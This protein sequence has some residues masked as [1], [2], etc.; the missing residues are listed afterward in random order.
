MTFNVTFNYVRFFIRIIIRIFI[1][2][3]N[4]IRLFI[5]IIIINFSSTSSWTRI[6]IIFIL[7][8]MIFNLTVNYRRI[9]KI[10]FSSS[11]F[12]CFWMEN[13]ELFIHLFFFCFCTRTG[14]DWFVFFCFNS[15]KGFVPHQRGTFTTI[16][17][18]RIL[19]LA[20][21]ILPSIL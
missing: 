14:L 11:T 8:I 19:R 18:V 16:I 10:L 2:S 4:I 1:S 15:P 17:D 5:I 3:F 12:N 13:Q 6:I 21:I 7:I 9:I 20:Y